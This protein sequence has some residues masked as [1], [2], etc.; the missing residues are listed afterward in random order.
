[1]DGKTGAPAHGQSTQY[2]ATHAAVLADY[3]TQTAGPDRRGPAFILY[4]LPPD[5][6]NHSSLLVSSTPS[7]H[8]RSYVFTTVL[9]LVGLLARRRTHHKLD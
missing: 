3:V 2:L 7:H 5:S 9:G 8:P 4:A 1:M 6:R